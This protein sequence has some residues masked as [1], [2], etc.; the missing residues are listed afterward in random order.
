M[1]SLNQT[2]GCL[3]F[4]SPDPKEPSYNDVC[5]AFWVSK[6]ITA[7]DESDVSELLHIEVN[8]HNNERFAFD[9]PASD[10]A[11]DRSL[12]MKLA[13]HRLVAPPTYKY[14]VPLYL[15]SEYQR[16]KTQRKIE[17]T[18]SRLGWYNHQGKEYFLHEQNDINGTP[19][20]LT[21]EGFSFR[22]GDEQTYT[23]FLR[24]VVCPVPTLALGLALGYSAVVVS[25]LQEE[26]DF[27][28][29][30]VNLCGA[31]STGK[32]TMEQLMIS[33]FASPKPRN[34]GGLIR[35]FHST[36]NALFAGL[37][38]IHGLPIALDDVTTNP[39][40]NIANLIY[41]LAGG[42]N[43]GRCTSEGKL[44]QSGSGW[45]GVIVIS[46]ET[47]I[48]EDGCQN[49]G[50]KVRVLHTQGITWT[51][52]AET[53]ERIKRTVQKHYGHT[54]TKFAEFVAGIP[55]DE[56]CDRFDAA[57]DAVH[58]LMSKRDNLS[59]RLEVKYAAMYLT[60]ELMNECFGYTLDTQE[61]ITILLQPE[62]DSVIERDVSRKALQIMTNFI[63]QNRSRFNIVSHN[64]DGV[65]DAPAISTNY[66]TIL[67]KGTVCEVFMPTEKVSEVL[68]S[69]GINEVTTVKK[70]WKEN[71]VTQCD[72][73]RYDCKK[74]SRRC[75]HFIFPDGLGNDLPEDLY[76]QPKPQ[77]TVVPL[78]PI[79][80]TVW[81]DDASIEN[82]FSG[83][84][85]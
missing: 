7:L 52:D 64:L 10:I 32:T 77:L 57:Q 65:Q 41:T 35:T 48:Q 63:L 12:L 20:H 18:H 1:L 38:G 31:S 5:A 66:G 46:S 29:I 6:I 53:A 9:L 70:R 21:R 44:K 14:F 15:F 42:D 8:D 25:R 55:L 74:L 30:I 68:K 84:P 61:L 37:D 36:Q 54:G 26:Y 13:N 39:Y 72:S 43:K 79:D 11:D 69:K 81:N 23:D 16:C 62:Q 24:D 75:I 78:T 28:T 40:I 45:S 17:F 76:P 51:P 50:L 22:K 82:I 60:V 4:I 2:N 73:D 80:D 67:F 83:D 27:G 33:P 34:Q 56:L 59:D 19:S 3:D 71:G 47:P 49:Q 58:T 85:F